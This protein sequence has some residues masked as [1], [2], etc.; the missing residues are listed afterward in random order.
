MKKILILLLGVLMCIPAFVACSP[1]LTD[2][3]AV[4]PMYFGGQ[5]TTVDPTRAYYDDANAK[6]ASL[7]YEC[8]TTVNDKGEV[9]LAA[10][11]EYTIIEKPENDTYGMEFVLKA[12]SWSDGRAVS[13]DDFAYAWRRLLD[14]AFHSEA[15]A[16][17]FDVRN[18]KA[19]N[20]G[21]LDG[22]K[23]DVG[24]VADDEKLT[25]YF[26]KPIDYDQFLRNLSAL[27]L[28]PLREDMV[29]QEKDNWG[30]IAS[31]VCGNGPFALK[32][33]V[34]G[35]QLILE[36][37]AY[38]YRDTKKEEFYDVVTPYRLVVDLTDNAD[39]QFARYQ[40]ENKDA[41]KVFYLGDFTDATPTGIDMDDLEITDTMTTHTYFFNT[42]KAPFD[43][44][45]VRRALSMAL[46][47]N[48]IASAVAF[49]K[50]ATGLIPAGVVETGAKTSFAEKRTASLAAN[51]TEAKAKIDA[52]GLSGSAK[53]FSISVRAG[54]ATAIAIANYAKTQWAELGFNVTIKELKSTFVPATRDGYAYVRDAFRT[55]LET[56]NFDV[57]AVDYQ[58]PTTDAFA[59]LAPFAPS[60]S[61][62]ATAVDAQSKH[63]TGYNSIAYEALIAAAADNRNPENRAKL[64]HDAENM[65]L[66]ELPVMPIVTLQNA[67]LASGELDGIEVDFRGFFRFDKL[68]LDHYEDY[69]TSATTPAA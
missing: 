69:Q 19:Y 7:L 23:Y 9:Q 30:S 1:E 10:A 6:I 64:L 59:T 53:S 34:Y 55:A 58:I 37:N 20:N 28:A 4:I 8:M 60:F 18:A 39:A 17:L 32:K 13:A 35:E 3:G 46:D 25:V 52:L 68:E 56:S 27:A 26:E 12:N 11:E 38:Y 14:P 33:F 21:K 36:R 62:S 49:T 48:S 57:I 44:V 43:N 51:M 29:T 41:E 16:L 63:V 66:D 15:A 61:G 24:I 45:E 65:L 42:T 47:R 5:V 2:K 22:S 50:A 54:D 31:L 67:Y 40:K